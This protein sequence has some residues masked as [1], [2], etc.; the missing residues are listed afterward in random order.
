MRALILV[1]TKPGRAVAVA[2]AMNRTKGVTRAFVV[3]GPT[4]V[5]A[6]AEV[7]SLEALVKLVGRVERMSAVT[8]TETLPELEAP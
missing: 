1:G 8:G 2:N 3:F 4:D 7:A 5:A 6:R